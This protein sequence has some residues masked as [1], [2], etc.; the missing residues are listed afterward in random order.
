MVSLCCCSK[1]AAIKNILKS[2]QAETFSLI[3]FSGANTFP[4]SRRN[5][6]L[7]KE[8]RLAK[9]PLLLPSPPVC[10]NSYPYWSFQQ[11]SPFA[12]YNTC[13]A[14]WGN[15]SDARSDSALSCPFEGGFAWFEQ[16]W[17]CWVWL[18]LANACFVEFEVSWEMLFGF[19]PLSFFVWDAFALSFLPAG[20]K[21]LSYS[22]GESKAL[23]P[24][25]CSRL[26]G[27]LLHTNDTL[28]W[29]KKSFGH[30]GAESRNC[31]SVN[32]FG[33]VQIFGW[34]TFLLPQ[35]FCKY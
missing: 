12:A 23:A 24:S 7:Y 25:N 5:S 14:V 33:G 28:K 18:V 3:C 6:I 26:G 8:T 29:G 11:V 15:Q 9:I 16:S 27:S 34:E 2:C 32:G 21:R 10:L 35:C 17:D 20:K 30:Q 1:A 4:P 19:F 31:P 13:Q 22:C